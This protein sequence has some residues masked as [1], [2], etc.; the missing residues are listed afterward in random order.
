MLEVLIFFTIAY[1]FAVTYLLG[2]VSDRARE[3]RIKAAADRIEDAE[4]IKNLVS[5]LA[6]QNTRIETLNNALRNKPWVVEELHQ[7]LFEDS[8]NAE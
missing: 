6:I 1:G 7:A 4:Q 2:R 3:N 8:F 5:R